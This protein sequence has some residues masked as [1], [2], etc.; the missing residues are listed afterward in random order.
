MIPGIWGSALALAF[1][2]SAE[3]LLCAN[4]V[5]AMHEGPRTNYDRELLAQGNG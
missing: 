1:V 5:D 3:T 2:A 4:A